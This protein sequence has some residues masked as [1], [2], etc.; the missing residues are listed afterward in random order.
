MILER[1]MK[2]SKP[3]PPKNAK[4]ILHLDLDKDIYERVERISSKLGLEPAYWVNMVLLSKIKAIESNKNTTIET[5]FT[6]ADE[7]RTENL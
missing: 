7:D 3:T 5:K 6:W 4:M 1:S 2:K